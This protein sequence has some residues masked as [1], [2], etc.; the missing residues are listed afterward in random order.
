[1]K[2][3][4]FFILLICSMLS[5]I[6]AANTND[7][8]FSVTVLDAPAV[9]APTLSSIANQA[10]CDGQ[11]INNIAITL[12]GDTNATLSATSSNGS[13]TPSITFSGTGANR[14]MSI[15][16]IKM[17]IGTTTITIT[18]T[19][20]DGTASQ[21]FL[22]EVG[23][24]TPVT[25]ST[26]AGSTQGFADGT[27][28]AARFYNP[29]GVAVDA[30]GT[31][32][33][34][35]PSN[36][37]IRKITPEGV[38]TTLAGNGSYGFADGIG[39]TAQFDSPIGVAVDASGN[40][41]VADFGNNKIRKISP[42][43][44]V[45]TLAGSTYGF[46]DGAG[47]AAQFKGPCSVA[48]DASGNVYVADAY[49]HKIRKITPAG[50][51][52]TL[53]GST[54]G[55]LDGTG[56]TAQFYT[57]YGVAVDASGN[58]YVADVVNYAIR[59]ITPGGAVTT[60]AGGT[61]GNADGAGT[62]AQFKDPYGVAVD[63][64]GNIYVADYGNNKIR[65]ITSAGEVTTLAGSTSGFADGTDTQ[66]QFKDPQGVAVD[67]SGN[68][69]VADASNNKI[70]K[71][72]D[73]SF[74]SCNA[75]P[76]FSPASL[77]NLSLC[78][79]TADT[80]LSAIAV[81]VSDDGTVESTTVTS[82]NTAL[83]TAANT[84]TASAAVIALTQKANQSG[85]ADITIES[86][87]NYGAKSTITYTVTVKAVQLTANLQTNVSKNAGSNGAASVNPATGGTAGYTYDWSPG[88]PTG[89]GTVSVTGLTAGTWTCTVTDA[90]S[91]QT[92]QS[93]T[94]TEPAPL[95]AI[96]SQTN[97]SSIR[98]SDGSATVSVSGGVP[99]YTYSWAPSGGTA[100]TASGLSAG[101]YQVTVTDAN[102][103]Q[104]TQSFTI[105]DPTL[106]AIAN[107]AVACDGQ[108]ISN[109]VL[110]LYGDTDAILSAASSNGSITPSITF[111]GTGADR[112]MDIA[113]IKGQAGTAII[114][115][116]ATR[117]GGTET[118]SFLLEVGTKNPAAVSTLAGSSEGFADGTG[119]QA[120]FYSP[121][122]VALDASGN[123]YVADTNN[124]KIRKIT[125]AGV[126]TTLAG[127]TKGFA[128]GTG[129]QAQFYSPIG[130]AVDAS[131]NVYVSDQSNH[132]IRKIT[133]GG[134]VTT[135]AGSTKGFADGTGTTAKFS[136]PQGI[137]VD[138]SGNVYVADISNHKIRKIT[139]AGEVTTLA[140][141]TSG[142]ADGTGPA[143][144]FSGPTGV[145]VDASGNV[146][147]ADKSNKKIRKITPAGVV[148]TLAGST[149][150]FADGTG[151]AAKFYYPT[152]VAVDAS[153]TV[154]VADQGDHKIRKITSAGEV[155]TLAG[156]TD[157][158]ADGINGPS[159]VAVDASGNVYVANTY[160]NKILTIVMDD[161][162]SVC[163][164][165]P[166]FSPVALSNLSLCLAASDTPL[167]DIPVTVSDD[168]TVVSTTVT[169][170]NTALVTAVNTGTA[171]AAVIALTQKANQSGTADITVESTDNNGATSTLTY[172]VTVQSVQLTANLQTNVSN[173]AGSNG[174]ASVNPAT[175]GTAGYTYDWSPGNPSGDGTVSVTGLT[176]GTWT[177]TVTDANSCQTTQSFTIT[178]PEALSF[179][180]KTLPGYD[181]NALYTQTIE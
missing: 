12:G 32:Y 87:D 7:N 122:G 44:S 16:T 71:I 126:V 149:Q 96:G 116:T 11:T 168:G 159:G 120:Q 22:L 24:K 26:L 55:F 90:N 101:T 150:G 10:V 57:P 77:P 30:S 131:G 163:N 21:T 141:S 47:T 142:F 61:F 93:F 169:S 91:C 42:A 81:N 174:A 165:K 177:C 39:A 104:T 133:P 137:T 138:A 110:T 160:S 49:N 161:S 46:A 37:R 80:A 72:V 27:G 34:A 29:R 118:Q 56:T 143:A 147:V 121:I 123:V 179:I 167:S 136:N 83:V 139:P 64:S 89:D 35:D 52:T 157:G 17:Q 109:V 156:S 140:G 76:L 162:Y 117:A 67:A 98:G 103:N 171:S 130:V 6:Y 94:I 18:A 8:A 74:S 20:T 62:A 1:M 2:K 146:Y 151:S 113:T 51:V 14:T 124:H 78:L 53:A 86:T 99:G 43:G 178:E 48:V 85:T 92:T 155:T 70:R 134:E 23:N 13:I 4:T 73:A 28:T 166:E 125:P 152:G 148:T 102:A 153:G 175:G 60:L 112:T 15:S 69:Y 33:I 95:V 25:V 19:G 181:S 107:Q 132:K 79:V 144:Q 172:T 97:V 106:S 164:A 88:N 40:V 111:S 119:A 129:T 31:V 128:D 105:T 180:T 41:Y 114:T 45:T 75:K 66:A 68:V 158:F 65:K 115:I 59:K 176:A 84:G 170:S 173:N 58:V 145:A 82:S 9:T 63:A 50:A 127:S 135:L 3:T 54:S 38:V 5:N 154:Y 108:T 100:A 36:N